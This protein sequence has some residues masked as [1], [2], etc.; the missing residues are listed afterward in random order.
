MLARQATLVM[1]ALPLSYPHVNFLGTLLNNARLVA[2][3]EVWR[4]WKGE[5][6]SMSSS[7]SFTGSS[8]SGELFSECFGEC[9]AWCACLARVDGGVALTVRGGS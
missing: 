2:F 5:A 1:A 9:G 3:L 7:S 6:P 8:S 4:R